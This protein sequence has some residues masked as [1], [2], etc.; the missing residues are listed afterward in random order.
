MDTQYEGL[1]RVS[2]EFVVFLDADERLTPLAIEAGLKCFDR[3]A[4]AWL[5]CG[6]HRVIDASGRPASRVWREKFAPKQCLKSPLGG[7]A[8]A[9]QAAAM[10]RTDALRS[11]IVP[12]DVEVGGQALPALSR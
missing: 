11:G 9:M 6:A 3:N 4:D 1:N 2:S 10:Y 12:I 7:N 5:V 8:I